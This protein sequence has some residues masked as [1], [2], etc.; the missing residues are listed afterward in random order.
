M[1][2]K[3]RKM[4]P[5]ERIIWDEKIRARSLRNKAILQLDEEGKSLRQIATILGTTPG[6]VAGI[7]SRHASWRDASKHVRIGPKPR[8]VVEVTESNGLVRHASDS[9]LSRPMADPGNPDGAEIVEDPV[10]TRITMANIKP[11]QCKYPIGDPK[12]WGIFRFCGERV[13]NLGPYCLEH[14]TICFMFRGQPPK[15]GSSLPR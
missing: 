9:D 14:H 11:T 15:G 8:A 13:H 6:Q 5:E 4:S 2:G 12:D 3:H 10:D 1:G 7:I